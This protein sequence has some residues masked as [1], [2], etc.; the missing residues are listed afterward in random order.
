MP[1]SAPADSASQTAPAPVAGERLKTREYVGYAL[2]DTA[3]N[4]FFQTFNIF[5]T[6]YYVDVWGIPAT[7]LLWMMPLVRLIGAFDRSEERRVGKE[8]R[9]R[10]SPYH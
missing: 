4:F 2:G 6:Y 10:W 3:S 7:A 5:L 9:S 1:N 8:C